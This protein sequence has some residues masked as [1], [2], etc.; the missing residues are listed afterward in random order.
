MEGFVCSICNDLTEKVTMQRQHT[1]QWLMMLIIHFVVM[2]VF[3]GS[4]RPDTKVEVD[5]PSN[6]DSAKEMI[7]SDLDN[8]PDRVIWQKPEMVL[9]LM[10]D[11]SNK[12][13][14]DLGAGSGFFTFRLLQK[15]KHVV[16]VDIDTSA[17]NRLRRLASK[18]DTSI[19]NKLTVKIAREDDPDLEGMRV[20]IVFLSNTYMYLKNRVEYLNTLKRYLAP[21]AKIIIVDYKKK[22][23]PFGPPVEEKL[24]LSV[25]ENELGRAGYSIIKSDDVSLDYQYIVIGEL[26]DPN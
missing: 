20:D 24:D 17:L 5:K 19:T 7:L 6:L 8:E 11:V 15:A 4:C 22:N 13:V 25:I 14:A 21:H 12:V 10:G 16:A 1:H 3:L 26:N 9:G 18:L 23:L 2:G